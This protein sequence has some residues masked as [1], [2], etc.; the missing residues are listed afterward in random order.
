MHRS[1]SLLLCAVISLAACSKAQE[2]PAAARR[3]RKTIALTTAATAPPVGTASVTSKPAPIP[4]PPTVAARGYFLLDYASGQ[5]I[6]EANANE[7]LEPASLTKLMTGYGV[8]AA[9]KEGRIKL[10]DEVM[11]SAHAR[12]QNGSRMFVDVGTRVKVEDLI[13]GM[14]VQSGNDATVAL[15]EHVAGSE[16]VFV[17]LMNQYAQQLGMKNTHFENSAGMPG[18]QHYTTAHDI[19][20]VAQAL[21]REFPNYY[22]WYSQREFTWNRI[23]Q[24]NRNGLLERD[25]TVDGLKTGHTESAGYCLVASAKRDRMRLISVV[26]GSP[27]VRSREDASAALLNYG[28]RFY[29]TRRFYAAN[30]PVTKVRVRKGAAPEVGLTL[31]QDLTAT[32]P[33]GQAEAIT[34]SIQI[35]EPLLAPLQRNKAIGTLKIVR[36]GKP[37]AEQPVY[38]SADVPETGFFGRLTDDIKMRFE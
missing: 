12:D 14:I 21:I 3:E 23:T 36:D 8:F 9:L 18:P 35:P 29:E 31:R 16:P 5:V 11:I 15:A 2:Q 38:P 13:Q 20:L 7:R 4:A 37:L 6:A 19:A 32:L 28:F 26:M 1:I 10:T 30:Q 22:K 33:R 25:P 34:A 27:N 17:D 24:P